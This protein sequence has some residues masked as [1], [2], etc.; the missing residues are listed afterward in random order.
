MKKIKIEIT[1]VSPLLQ[2]RFP[3][4]ESEAK[5]KNKKSMQDDV[6]R[7]LY[8]HPDGTI[9]QPAIHLICSLKKAGAKFKIPGQGK[10][11]YKNLIGSGAIIIWPDAIPHKHQSFEIDARPVVVPATRGRVVRKRPVFKNWAFE[12]DLEYDEDEISSATLREL[13][14]YAGK[15]VGI[16]D[17]RPERGGPF[18]R[19]MVSEFKKYK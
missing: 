2:H 8:R 3:V 18:G 7:S 17:F 14:D 19:F 5:I 15:R 1:G 6:E 16:G 13:L 9:Y 4:E 10:L 11:T 12:F